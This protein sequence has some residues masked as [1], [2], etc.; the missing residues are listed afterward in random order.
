[1]YR[2]QLKLALVTGILGIALTL[3]MTIIY[4]MHLEVL[5]EDS[6]E[7]IRYTA[8]VYSRAVVFFILSLGI[9]LTSLAFLK[10]RKAYRLMLVS[11]FSAAIGYI[12][13][14]ERLWRL[15]YANSLNETIIIA[16]IHITLLVS[17]TFLL[18]RQFDRYGK[19]LSE[20]L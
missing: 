15:G 8:S 19:I 10:E 16:A 18:K 1:M 5:P 20:R 14:I 11:T 6:I 3:F 12:F 4:Y 13:P 7:V 9:G 2:K 17:S